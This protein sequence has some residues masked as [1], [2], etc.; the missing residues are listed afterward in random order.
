[1]KRIQAGKKT[2]DGAASVPHAHQAEACL[3]RI[4]ELHGEGG[5][6]FIR[7]GRSFL[8]NAL[9]RPVLAHFGP[10]D[11]HLGEFIAARKSYLAHDHVATDARAHPVAVLE[12]F[13]SKRS[14]EPISP[15]IRSDA[16]P[17]LPGTI[18]PT[19]RHITLMPV[20]IF[21]RKRQRIE[22]FDRQYVGQHMPFGPAAVPLFGTGNKIADEADPISRRQCRTHMKG[23]LVVVVM[24]IV[25]PREYAPL[26]REDLLHR[27]AGPHT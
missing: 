18:S 17:S 24:W 23:R 26:D 25:P 13:P 10:A 20:I 14:S 15:A 3:I 7:T 1:M 16:G 2:G 21:E 5:L 4:D 6:V 9:V 22:R 8:K 11:Q 12:D 19:W 27:I